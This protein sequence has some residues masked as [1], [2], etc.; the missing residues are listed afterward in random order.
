[1]AALDKALGLDL[2]A[3]QRGIDIAHRAAACALLAQQFVLLRE[4]I[5]GRVL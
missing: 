4:A 2:Q 3:L 5:A 1:M